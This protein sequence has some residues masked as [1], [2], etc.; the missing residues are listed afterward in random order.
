[1][2]ELQEGGDF[3][4]VCVLSDEEAVVVWYKDGKKLMPSERVQFFALGCKRGIRIKNA[5]DADTGTYRCETTD[6]RSRTE[7]EVFIKGDCFF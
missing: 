6:G 2:T 5:T 1:M 4:L 3:E 7:G